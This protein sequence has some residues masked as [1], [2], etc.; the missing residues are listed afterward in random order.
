MEFHL[1]DNY[2]QLEQELIEQYHPKYNC[3]RAYT[4]VAWNGN[5]AEYKKEYDEKY[6][7]NKQYY[8]TKNKQHNCESE[9]SFKPCKFKELRDFS[10]TVD[11]FAFYS[12]EKP[13]LY[14]YIGSGY[15]DREN[16]PIHTGTFEADPS[17][18]RYGI[19][20]LIA[21]VMRFAKEQ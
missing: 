10:L 1:T 5:M 20:A 9:N 13:G 12:S 4:G 8:E 3:L 15:H 16:S 14:F 18:I 11:D 19:E 2:K 17:S 21:L 7:Y 6:Q